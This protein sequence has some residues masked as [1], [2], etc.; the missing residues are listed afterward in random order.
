MKSY[1]ERV[2]YD[3]Y[4]AKDP[5]ADLEEGDVVVVTKEKQDPFTGKAVPE[6]LVGI[7]RSKNGKGFDVALKHSAEN[8]NDL[9]VL[10]HVP[11]H[12]LEYVVEKEYDPVCQR[13]SKGV[14]HLEPDNKD[15]RSAVYRAMNKL[16]FVPA[17][18]IL[19]GLGR[20]EG[21]DLTLFN[22]Y[23]FSIPGDS[24]EAIGSHWLRLLNTYATGGGV[25]W[26]LSVLRPRG[27]I[28]HKVNGRSSGA[29]SWAEE[30]SQVTGTVEQGGSRRGAGLQ[31]LWCWH[32]DI[33]EFIEA[34]SLYTRGKTREGEWI[35]VYGKLLTN[36]N[37]SVMI[38]DDFMEAVEYNADW[39]LVFPDTKEPTYDETWDG[40]LWK[41]K[42]DGKPVEI[43]RT[44]KA[45]E[46]WEKIVYHAW[47]SGEPGLI[48]LERANKMSNSYYYD[49]IVC[50]N[51]CG[52]Y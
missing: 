37:V 29:V 47:K 43:Y 16:E 9:E 30:F 15:F 17:G 3:R 11:R 28:V 8:D 31:G 21:Y 38:S 26:N 49:R 14:V 19:A 25:G 34:K 33:E 22:C 39:D 27:S 48:F 46:L 42:R 10:T 45:K 12:M 20:G 32:P 24:R 5:E 6:R 50:T 4:S 52:F 13:V 23:V 44:V 2:L 7:I 40:D 35:D 41:W 51:P 36:S 1:S 18:R